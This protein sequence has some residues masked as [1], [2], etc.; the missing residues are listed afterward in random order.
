MNIPRLILPLPPTD[1]NLR[2]PI[3]KKCTAYYSKQLKMYV[4]FRPEII[5]SEDYRNWEKLAEKAWSD[6]IN[7]L[8]R[9]GY[10]I[11]E[12]QLDKPTDKIRH[13][14]NY[15]LFKKSNNADDATYHKALADFLT[16][17]LYKDDRFVKLNLVHSQVQVDKDNPRIEID[18]MPIHHFKKQSSPKKIKVEQL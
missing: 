2:I 8:K 11:D 4:N 17:R 1:N 16:G 6:W 9:D 14:Y 10:I 18:V 12:E 15:F 3:L 7:Q 5:K 13:E